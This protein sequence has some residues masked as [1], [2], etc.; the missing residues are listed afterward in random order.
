MALNPISGPDGTV[1]FDE[2]ALPNAVDHITTG[3]RADLS[4]LDL[5]ALIDDVLEPED[6]TIATL[7][8][9]TVA[10]SAAAT[11]ITVEGSN[12]AADSVIEID[13]VAVATTFVDDTTLT[14]SYDPTVAATVQFSVRNANEAE[15]NSVPF[16]VSAAADE[17][18]DDDEEPTDPS[19]TAFDPSSHNIEE[20]RTYVNTLRNQGHGR[21]ETQ[22]V[23]D[24]ERAGQNRVTLIEWL[25]SKL[26]AV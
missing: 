8:P 18:A 20:V 16:V 4:A 23:L 26:G 11:L 2:S 25:D 9:S 5:G 10:A 22:R 1:L 14:T 12:F 6:P 19:S 7:T 17:P 3:Q 13:Q 21:R 15:S 24:A